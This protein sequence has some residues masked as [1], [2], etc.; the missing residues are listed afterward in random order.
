MVVPSQWLVEV[1]ACQLH[2]E[3]ILTPRIPLPVALKDALAR[4]CVFTFTAAQTGRTLHWCI[5]GRSELLHV[6]EALHQHQQHTHAAQTPLFVFCPTQGWTSDVEAM[7]SFWLGAQ[8]VAQMGDSRFLDIS[9]CL[10]HGFLYRSPDSSS[11]PSVMEEDPD[12]AAAQD[13][14]LA[15][16]E[17]D[18]SRRRK[19]RGAMPAAMTK[20]L[21][22][23]RPCEKARPGQPLCVACQENVASVVFLDCYHVS[24]C[25]NCICDDWNRGLGQMACY[26]CRA[27]CIQGP[28]SLYI[29][30]Y[31][32]VEECN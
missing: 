28:A 15:Q 2:S 30:E 1:V 5:P 32:R 3:V 25:E 21:C 12:L 22:L 24:A 31:R 8:R 4:C 27:P 23:S 7:L 26:V 6:L 20:R 14:S 13:A 11:P 29:S 10:T 9:R 16:E 19:S 18:R 17:E